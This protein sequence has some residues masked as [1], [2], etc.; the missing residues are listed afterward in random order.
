MLKSIESSV[1]TNFV[2]NNHTKQCTI[3]KTC[4]KHNRK[5]KTKGKKRKNTKKVITF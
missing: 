4:Y 3:T 1:P 2:A 5:T